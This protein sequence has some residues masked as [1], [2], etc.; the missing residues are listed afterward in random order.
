MQQIPDTH[1]SPAATP[2][3]NVRQDMKLPVGTHLC[4]LFILSH[5]GPSTTSPMPPQTVT[6][7]SSPVSTSL[8]IIGRTG[9]IMG[10]APYKMKMMR[11]LKSD[12]TAFLKLRIRVLWAY[13]AACNA[14]IPYELWFE[15]WLLHFR[16][17]TLLVSLRASWKMA[18]VLGPWHSHRTL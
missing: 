13:N 16:S 18:Y 10:S 12:S 6:P 15:P 7:L 4:I 2:A 3:H 1:S 11:S 14:S 9:C 8:G 17:R 5:P